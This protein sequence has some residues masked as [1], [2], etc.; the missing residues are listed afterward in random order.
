MKKNEKKTKKIKKEAWQ[1]A[2]QQILFAE[3]EGENAPRISLVDE[4]IAFFPLA[5]WVVRTAGAVV[6]VTDSLPHAEGLAADLRAFFL[7]VGVERA[8]HVLPELEQGAHGFV[9]ESE[10]E[11]IRIFDRSTDEEAVFVCSISAVLAAA[12]K[13]EKFRDTFLELQP[14]TREWPPQRLATY[15]TEM[16]YDNEALV[17]IPGEFSLRGG[18][19]DVFSPVDE[20]PLRLDYFG[21]ELESIRHFDPETQRSIG[22]VRTCRIIPRGEQVL[23]D[24]E[25]AEEEATAFCFL[26]YFSWDRAFLTLIAPEMIEAHLEQYGTEAMLKDWSA[27][28]RRT[29]SYGVL[30]DRHSEPPRIEQAKTEA[31]PAFALLAFRGVV[32]EEGED[33]AELRQQFLQQQLERWTEAGQTVVFCSEIAQRREEILKLTAEMPGVFTVSATLS[34]GFQCPEQRLVVLSE[35]EVFGRVQ[36]RPKPEKELFHADYLLHAGTELSVGDYV[37]HASYGVARF[38]GI[39]M[40]NFYGRQQEVFTLEFADEARVH[41]PLE[42][43]YLLS[44]YVG[45]GK[46]IP[47]LSRIGATQW[48]RLCSAAEEAVADLAAELIR[49]QAI[50][51]AAPG[52]SF[53]VDEE[54][55]RQFV[56]AFPYTETG[57]Q[58]RAAQEVEADMAAPRP[59]DR[60]VCG[61]VGFGK[62]EIAMRAAFRAVLSGKQVVVLAPTTILVQQHYLTFSER[63]RDFPV[64]IRF[65]SRFQTS[66]QQR[67]VLKELREGRVD[68]VVGTHRLLGKDVMF[69]DLG[70]VVVDEEQRFGVRHKERLKQLRVNVDLLTMTATPIPRTL[71]LSLSGARDMSTIVTPPVARLPVRTIVAQNDPRLVENAIRRE[72]QRGGQVYYLHNRV[73]SIEG[74]AARLAE[75]VPEAVIDVGHGQMDE[76]QLESVM[77]HFISGDIDVLVCTTII[78]SGMDIP[79]V[80]TIIIDRAD[81]FGLA[82][83]YQLRGRVGRYHRQAYAYLLL[84]KYAVLQDTARARLSAIRKYTQLGAGFKLAVRDLEIRGAGNLLGPEQSGHINAVGF[85]LYCRLLQEAV[86]RLKNKEV[87]EVPEVDVILD[88]L[89]NGKSEST[90]VASACFSADYIVE[91]D[92]RVDVYRRLSLLRTEKDWQDFCAEL[93]D[94]FGLIPLEAERMLQYALLRILAMERGLNGVRVKERRVFL[95]HQS[96]LVKTPGGALPQLTGETPDELLAELVELVRQRGHISA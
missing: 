40:E 4:E 34:S 35:T 75:L 15:L 92:L 44:R 37:V 31:F 53:Q 54:A 52:V 1:E 80:N 25:E 33:L 18:V 41:V 20:Y 55:Y 24:S 58:I 71:Y 79:N 83:L 48:K 90:A 11:R 94:R 21:D 69:K 39:R 73:Q 12:P 61:D 85:N 50:R 17:R 84:P 65:L 72:L 74:V 6:V 91:E 38:H 7:L 56:A 19:L 3:D 36:A 64:L 32:T 60:L 49:I 9:P 8:V 45:A 47:K 28:L 82:A 59:M 27:W 95:Q 57:D 93:R 87:P 5:R 88:F 96:G 2:L 29:S 63:F 62:T 23:L 30:C 16:D 81:R 42:Q 68:I 13:P 46:R 86:G 66:A 77:L 51:D 26:D 78:E 43:A 22:E 67:E 76:H 89:V 14:G 10:S 70:L